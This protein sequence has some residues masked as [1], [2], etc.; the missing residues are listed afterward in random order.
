MSFC[1]AYHHYFIKYLNMLC[2]QLYLCTHA[3]V[4]VLKEKK[5]KKKNES[6]K[7]EIKTNA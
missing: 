4:N 3:Y 5:N 2:N 6:E 7:T 1:I